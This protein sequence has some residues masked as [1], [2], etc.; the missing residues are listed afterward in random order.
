MADDLKNRRPQDRSRINISE[1]WELD[2]WTKE[3]GVSRDELKRLVAQHGNSADAV[4][5]ALR[6]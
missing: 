6:K 3:L 2:Y 1:D 4:Q 5:Q